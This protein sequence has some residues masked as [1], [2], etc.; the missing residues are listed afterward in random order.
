V[1]QTGAEY[2]CTENQSLSLLGIILMRVYWLVRKI[3]FEHPR[4]EFDY[5]FFP[6]AIA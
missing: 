2:S 6:A 1:E 4:S 5:S 3:S